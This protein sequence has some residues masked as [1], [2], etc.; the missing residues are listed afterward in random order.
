[1]KFVV[2]RFLLLPIGVAVALV[3]ANSAAGESYFRFAHAL[4][5]PVNEI[6]MAL[7][8]GLLAQETY[9]AVMPGGAMH[10][11]RRWL[12]ALIAAAGGIAGAVLVFVAYVQIE[13]E[14][15]LL[16]AWPVVCAIDMAA[17]Y[18]LLKVLMPRSAAVPFLL[19]LASATNAAGLAIVAMRPDAVNMHPVGPLL[20]L[21]A[22]ATCW[23]LRRQRIRNFVPF[24]AVG[25]TL[26][27]VGFYFAGLHPALA[28]VPVVPF[29][30]H[31][32]RANDV[33][34]DL[35]DDDRVHHFEHRWNGAV[36]VVLLFFG[37]VNGGVLLHGYE[38]GTWAVLT[39]ALIGRPAGILAAV[40]LAHLAGLSLPPRFGWRRL[41]VVA[42]ATSTGFAF[43]LFFASGVLP[44]GAV[45][46]QVKLGALLTIVGGLVTL[47]VA[48]LLTR[49]RSHPHPAGVFASSSR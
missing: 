47:V 25:G 35:P 48:R 40:G 20:I 15:M 27:W 10:T 36:Q 42:F 2:D 34:A 5:F 9:E 18:Y 8:L 21:V 1:M 3:W 23:L 6:G 29:L 32:P 24:I 16:E 44:M 17:A 12:L 38:T 43:A 26:S 7:F 45:L 14:P 22:M 37:L 49:F 33:F 39:A 41:V 28:L 30:P 4:A 13:Y 31:E 11:C 46:T 19:I